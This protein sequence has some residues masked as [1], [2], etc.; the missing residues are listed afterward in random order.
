MATQTVSHESRRPETFGELWA[1]YC[2]ERGGRYVSF[3]TSED[4]EDIARM[5]WDMATRVQR[6]SMNE[7][8]I[9]GKHPKHY[10][11]EVVT[12]DPDHASADNPDHVSVASYCA[13]CVNERLIEERKRKLILQAI[14]CPSCHSL[15]DKFPD[16]I[17]E[18]ITNGSTL[19]CPQCKTTIH[20]RLLVGETQC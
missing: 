8:G 13:L 4:A 12:P 18:V 16:E 19:P 11:V 1:M 20:I 2:K 7:T 17:Q 6:E 10:W 5:A 15:I 3:E 9:C 14:E